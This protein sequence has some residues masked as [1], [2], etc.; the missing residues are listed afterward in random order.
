MGLP[1]SFRKFDLGR[2]TVAVF[3]IAAAIVCGPYAAFSAPVFD[4]TFLS[5]AKPTT[6]RTEPMTSYRFAVG[7]FALGR[8]ATL[9]AEGPL[10]Q[11]AFKI[12]APDQSTLQL[13]Q[14]LRDQ[15]MAAGFTVIYEC[16]TQACGGFDFRY[17]IEMIA[18]PDMHVDLGDFRYLAA[19]RRADTGD[20]MLSLMVSKSPDHGFVQFTQVGSFAKAA[21]RMAAATKSPGLDAVP[22]GAP[23]PLTG[24][25]SGDLAGLLAATLDQ[26]LP[27]VLED[28]VFTSG[29]SALA[30]DDFASLRDLAVWLRGNPQR[31]VMV[32]GH[33]D[34]SGSVSANQSLS[35][36]RAQSVRQRLIGE[37]AIPATQ[38]TADGV[39][40]SVPRDTNATNAGRQKNR[41]VEV[42]TTSAP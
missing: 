7:P 10:E 8:V 23:A 18:E 11:T 40:S 14:P 15:I 21:P 39:G 30:T 20:E 4:L 34:A 5:P 24:S 16:E 42:M 31:A 19:T 12:D 38:I 33:T 36:L 28:L 35:K 3:A 13:L 6:S 29:S 41:R 32:V 17:G 2:R 37:F 26:G 27:M 22:L 1:F 9:V 25:A